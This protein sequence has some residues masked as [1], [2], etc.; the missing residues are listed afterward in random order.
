MC[1]LR[2]TGRESHGVKV[3]C[4]TSVPEVVGGER[5]IEKRKRQ[6]SR[7]RGMGESSL[8]KGGGLDKPRSSRKKLTVKLRPRVFFG[9][10]RSIM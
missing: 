2:N 9:K 5:K 4:L 3:H 6:E 10:Y 7:G 8:E 1:E